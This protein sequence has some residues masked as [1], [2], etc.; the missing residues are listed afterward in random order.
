[1]MTF[2]ALLAACAITLSSSTAFAVESFICSQTRF[3]KTGFTTSDVARSFYPPEIWFQIDGDTVPAS[4]YGEG[5]VAYDGERRVLSMDLTGNSSKLA[6]AQMKIRVFT[7][8]R[9]TVWL[10]PQ[11]GYVVPTPSIYQCTSG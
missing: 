3:A 10:N 11:V 8:G 7:S 4:F 9:A 2:K 1:M 5:V 6:G